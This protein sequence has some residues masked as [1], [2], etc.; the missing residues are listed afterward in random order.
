[1]IV[2]SVNANKRLG[3]E[4]ARVRFRSWLERRRVTIVVVQEA[5]RAGAPVPPRLPGME[6]LGGDH[7]LAVWVRDAACRSGLERPAEWWQTVCAREL[8][9]HSV[10]LDPYSG[11]MRV[12][13]LRTLTEQLP[14]SP[15]LVLGDFN[16]APRP[17]DGVYGTSVSEFTTA[18]ERHAFA[19]LLEDR[20]LVDATAH[21]RPEFTLSRRIRGVDSSFRCDLALLPASLA[22]HSVVADHK[23][24]IGP[25]AFTDHS[26]IVVSVGHTAN[27][28]TDRSTGPSD[29]RRPRPPRAGGRRADP[30]IADSFKTAIARGGPSAPAR[31]LTPFIERL[32]A[33][34]PRDPSA[35][36]VLDYGCGRGADVDYYRRLGIDAEGYDPHAPFGFA[37]P[38]SALFRV[39][40]L[41]FVLNVLPTIEA[42]LE[43]IRGA[44]A[45]LAPEGVLIVVTRSA[46]AVRN[47]ATRRNWRAW[48]DGFISHEGR[49]TFQHGMDTPEIAG[50][51]EMLNLRSYAPLPLVRD[52]STVA[53]ADEDLTEGARQTARSAG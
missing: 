18:R 24:R 4:A 25:H 2:A 23:T 12:E 43:A 45:Q 30:T 52:A 31:G 6:L 39:V 48:G 42:R 34:I 32:L 49:G 37:E 14:A 38:P 10:H 44:V 16:L 26:G 8:V 13:Q 46:A 17:V 36:S 22:T 1:M 20:G 9:I 40:T 28:P 5:W 27:R 21:D 33:G 51:G 29:R 11:A 53:L 15:N 19:E 35:R 3:A 41:V 50:L 47:E 7:E